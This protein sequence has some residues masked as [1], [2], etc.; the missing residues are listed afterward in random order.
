MEE[1]QY[2]QE[3][4]ERLLYAIVAGFSI[5]ILNFNGSLTTRALG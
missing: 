1:R 3:I 2:H 4:Q 5:T